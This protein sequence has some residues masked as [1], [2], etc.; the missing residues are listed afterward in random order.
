[1]FIP[2]PTAQRGGVSWNQG[3]SPTSVDASAPYFQNWRMGPS[4]AFNVVSAGT[5]ASA[6][7]VAGIGA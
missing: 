1:V 7:A 3:R 6:P 5:S 2:L 4:N